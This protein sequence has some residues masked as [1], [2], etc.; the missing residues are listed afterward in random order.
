M[1]LSDA[2]ALAANLRHENDP[3]ELSKL[4]DQAANALDLFADT[5]LACAT[6]LAAEF[7]R[8]GE[9]EALADRLLGEAGKA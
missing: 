8:A 9:G 3:G 2:R 6:R 1:P 7:G 5:L 4:A